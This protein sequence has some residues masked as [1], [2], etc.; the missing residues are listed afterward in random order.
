MHNF[1]C[2]KCSSFSVVV[3]WRR[4]LNNVRADDLQTTETFEDG[5]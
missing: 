1:G 5:Q 2:G 4:D 3:E